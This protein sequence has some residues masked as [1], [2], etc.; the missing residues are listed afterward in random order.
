M[1]L[2]LSTAVSLL[3][4]HAVFNLLFNVVL[5]QAHGIR[6]CRSFQAPGFLRRDSVPVHA[7]RWL[8][9]APLSSLWT[10]R[11]CP[12]RGWG[13]QPRPLPFPVPATSNHGGLGRGTGWRMGHWV[14]M[15]WALG[16][17]AGM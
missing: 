2:F 16:H 7:T 10:Q 17:Q 12:G 6:E 3:I 15:G 5:P 9:V 14:S 11:P 8:Q 13:S 4:C 1:K